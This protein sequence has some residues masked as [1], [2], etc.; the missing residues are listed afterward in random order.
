MTSMSGEMRVI[1]VCVTGASHKLAGKPCQDNIKVNR[2]F[3]KDM[4]LLA[5]ADG[6]GSDKSP[7]SEEGSKIAV[8]VFHTIISAAFKKHKND[9][10]KLGTFLHR[11]GD[12]T[13]AKEI[14]KEWKS[15]VRKSHRVNN[16]SNDD[17][18][19]SDFN[20]WRQYGSTLLGLLIT[21]SFYFAFQ[22][23]DGDILL[24]TENRAEHIISG[25]KQLGVDTHSLCHDESWRKAITQVRHRHD[26]VTPHAFML[27]TDGFSNSYPDEEMFLKTCCEYYT[28]INLHG[29]NTVWGRLQRW[30][31]ETSEKGSGDD[32]SVLI[33]CDKKL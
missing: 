16:R 7:F 17:D 1:G 31:E 25:D 6:H 15:R 11:E 24:L 29:T 14:E 27:T 2:V 22:L 10:N 8:D 9:I 32:I 3:K 13:I 12:T 19:K 20:L 26:D 23:G 18:I 30:L 33:A 21:S 4:T 5:V 28:A